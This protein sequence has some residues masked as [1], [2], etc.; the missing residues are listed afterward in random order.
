MNPLAAKQEAFEESIKLKNQFRNL[1][2]DEV[3]FLDSVLE[4][5]RKKEEDVKRETTEQLDLFRRQQEEADKVL[6]E[7]GRD[8]DGTKAEAGSP[9]AGEGQW[10]VNA[11]KRKRVKEKESLKGVKIRKSSSANETSVKPSEDTQK[12][13]TG[14][15][16]SVSAATVGEQETDRTSTSPKAQSV[17][18]QE[19]VAKAKTGNPT[20]SNATGLGLAGYS[21]D[22]EE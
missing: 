11:R 8:A 20:P 9:E 3:E 12:S 14:K 15:V 10:A 18:G 19:A 17:A 5:T 13:E 22:E 1:D 16:G 2:E 4:S 7:E 21:S 6:L